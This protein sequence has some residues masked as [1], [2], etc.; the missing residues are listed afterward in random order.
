M[1]EWLTTALSQRGALGASSHPCVS[2]ERELGCMRQN[3]LWLK[4][5]KRVDIAI[6]GDSA[7]GSLV[8]VQ[9]E[10]ESTCDRNATVRKLAFGLTDQLRF[11]NNRGVDICVVAGFY[12]PVGLGYVEKVSC[13]WEN[14]TFSHVITATPLKQEEVLPAIKAV[15]TTQAG[16]QLASRHR[17]L[18]LPLSPAYVAS[19]WGSTAYQVPSGG[20]IVIMSPREKVVYKYPLKRRETQTLQNLH[21]TRLALQ[22]CSF[23]MSVTPFPTCVNS[24]ASRK[25]FFFKFSAL[26]QPLAIQE[27]KVVILPLVEQVVVALE[28]LHDAGLA[29]QDVRLDNICFHPETGAAVL[30][31]LDMSCNASDPAHKKSLYGPSTLYTPPDRS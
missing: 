18:T 16:Y 7:V 1:V 26:Q 20:S 30:I 12:V 8:Y 27:A 31:D 29:H 4:A 11:L 24:P 9:F 21:A 5:T 23:P 19:I 15:Y 3:Q 10:I 22:Q 14:E 17:E 6:H 28:E 25:M 2:A 13:T